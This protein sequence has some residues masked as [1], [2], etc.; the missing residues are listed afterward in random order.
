MAASRCEDSPT[1]RDW[2]RPH[3]QGDDNNISLSCVAAKAWRLTT[4]DI[5]WRCMFLGYY[6]VS[7]G[8][9]LPTKCSACIFTASDLTK[10]HSCWTLPMLENV[11][12]GSGR[13]LLTAQRYIAHNWFLRAKGVQTSQELKSILRLMIISAS[14]E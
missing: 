9:W 1:F 12:W 11:G 4:T 6:S 2:L 3:L 8:E 7:L 10:I 14:T 13:N 5:I